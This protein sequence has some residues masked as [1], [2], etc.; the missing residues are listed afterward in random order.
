MHIFLAGFSSW[1]HRQLRSY[2][3]S[4][5][6][7]YVPDNFYL[8]PLYP[9]SAQFVRQTLDYSCVR[10]H[11]RRKAFLRMRLQEINKG[12]AC[13]KWAQPCARVSACT[14]IK[15]TLRSRARIAPAARKTSTLAMSKTRFL[16]ENLTSNVLD[17]PRTHMS[18]IHLAFE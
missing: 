4:G 7:T 12:G 16:F 15:C 9:S 18:A 14:G 1:Q 3:S 2:K 8:R 10:L 5:C 17:P 13:S 6:P 11:K